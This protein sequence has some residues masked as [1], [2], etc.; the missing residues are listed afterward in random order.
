MDHVTNFILRWLKIEPV[1]FKCID[2]RGQ[3]QIIFTFCRT[4]I[5]NH[6]KLYKYKGKWYF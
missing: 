6:K 4:K 3:E 1:Y 5:V 2:K